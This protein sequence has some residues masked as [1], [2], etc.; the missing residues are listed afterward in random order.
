MAKPITI[1][2]D[3]KKILKEHLYEGKNG[4]KYLNLAIFE[5]R[6]GL[7][8]FGNSHY[9]VQDIP[10]EARDRGEKGPILG[11]AKI[12]AQGSSGQPDRN[13]SRPPVKDDPRNDYGR[14][15]PSDA[16]RGPHGGG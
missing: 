14:T 12:E 11:N 9:V 6:D 3:V 16:G 13:F 7:D 8:R 1:R 4:A 15:R 10:K 2:I 5:N